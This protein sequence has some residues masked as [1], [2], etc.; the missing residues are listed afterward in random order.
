MCQYKWHSASTYQCHHTSYKI[1]KYFLTIDPP[2]YFHCCCWQGLSQPLKASGLP[3]SPSKTVGLRLPPHIRACCPDQNSQAEQVGPGFQ[4]LLPTITS[5]HPIYRQV[6]WG[7]GKGCPDTRAPEETLPRVGEQRLQPQE[8]CPE[9]KAA[10]TVGTAAGRAA[11]PLGRQHISSPQRLL[12]PCA[13]LAR[14][15]T[16]CRALSVKP[17]SITELTSVHPSAHLKL[18]KDRAGQLLS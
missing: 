17:G 15:P 7:Q 3:Q 5:T 16:C 18:M 8:A 10:L 11:L 12:S 4:L 13:A 6:N 9:Q 14:I 1:L 2:G